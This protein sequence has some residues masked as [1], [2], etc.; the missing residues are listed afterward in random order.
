MSTLTLND[1]TTLSYDCIGQGTPILFL[2]GIFVSRQSWQ[3]QLDYFAVNHQVITCDLRGHGQS[4]SSIGPYNIPL[5]ADDLVALLDSLGIEKVACCG[6][7]FG[8]MVAQELALNHPERISR[9]ILAE[10]IHGSW[11]TPLD[12]MWSMTARF[13]MP[14]FFNTKAQLDLFARF[15]TMYG[16]SSQQAYAFI[17][18]ELTR[19]QNDLTNTQNI[20]Q[21]AFEFSSR[22]RLTQITC[23]TLVMIGQYFLPIYPHAY[24]M[25]LQIPNVELVTIPNAGHVLN[26]DNPTLFNETI[27]RFLG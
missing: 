17:Q 3:P 24:E 11:I 16:P 5:L 4:G 12:A 13:L 22:S 1:K 14:H 19:H 10:T 18:T 15:F 20:I 23:P 25:A 27:T 9:L 26:W 8:G 2:H 21:A 6:H 7:S